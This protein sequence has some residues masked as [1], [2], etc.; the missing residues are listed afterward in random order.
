MT[1]INCHKEHEHKFC[2]NCGEKTNVDKITFA[3]LIQNGASTIT[4]MDKGFL[5]NIKSL[6]VDPK[7]F[8]Q[9]Y[10]KGKRKGILNPISF[11]I[12]CVTIYLIADSF[13]ESSGRA[14]TDVSTL[15]SA[16]LIGYE[17]GII[18]TEYLKYFWILSILWLSMAT[19]FFVGKY[20]FTEHLAINSFVIGL[21]TL[22]GSVF[23]L[24]SKAIVYNPIIYLF[25]GWLLY[26][27]HIVEN[28][29]TDATLISFASIFFF[30]VILFIVMIVIGLIKHF[31]SPMN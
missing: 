25:M 11:L 27:I 17:A 31:V 21:S 6:I 4:N 20:N 1:C 15:R 9:D 5:Y 23:L 22:M 14:K 19:K 30:F 16:K 12:I 7:K 13:V 8:V 28:K 2:P 18:I 24:V 29:K 3:S 26:K 10:I